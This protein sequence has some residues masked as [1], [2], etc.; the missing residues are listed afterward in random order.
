MTAMASPSIS[1]RTG[2]GGQWSPRM[3]SLRFSPLP[4]PRKNRPGIMAVTVA[5]AWAM[6]AG[7]MRIVGQVTPVPSR[8]VLV[9]A[10]MAPI[11]DQTNDA[12]PC[13]SNHGWKWSEMAAKSNPVSSARLA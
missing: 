2:A 6:I 11:T 13:W 12:W 8:S 3:C 5:A 10:E 7:W 4:T 9:A 1:W